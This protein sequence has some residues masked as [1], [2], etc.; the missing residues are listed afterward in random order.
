MIYSKKS[1]KLVKNFSSNFTN[2][3]RFNNIIPNKH[4][5]SIT[6]F[7]TPNDNTN[8]FTNVNTR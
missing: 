4:T 7:S 3:I 8:K 2:H 1:I 6:I 5:C